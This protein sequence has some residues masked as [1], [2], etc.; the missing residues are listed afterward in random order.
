MYVAAAAFFERDAIIFPYYLPRNEDILFCIY[1]KI[2]FVVC[3]F[4]AYAK[5]KINALHHH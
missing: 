2:K 3:V 5:Q 4:I 1:N